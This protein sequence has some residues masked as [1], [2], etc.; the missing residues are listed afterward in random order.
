MNFADM[1]WFFATV[2]GTALLAASG[3]DAPK[4]RTPPTVDVSA[5][6]IAARAMPVTFEHVAQ[7]V[8]AGADRVEAGMEGD[9]LAVDVYREKGI[10]GLSLR[11]PASGWP[12]AVIVRLHG[13]P[14]LE[15]F[16]VDAG[17]SSLICELQ[18]PEG[19]APEQVCR[20]GNAR[21]EALTRTPEFFQ[22]TLP[23]SILTPAA[24]TAELHWVD[25]WR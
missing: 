21:L 15:S 6:H 10:G 12:A 22:V 13:F 25:Q 4:S 2:V 9:T 7:T 23:R 24:Q 1:G 11:V 18:R 17:D 19:R 5:P 3:N 8:P 16:K 20:I 14:D